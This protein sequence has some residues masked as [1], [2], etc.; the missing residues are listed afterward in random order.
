[1]RNGVL[2]VAHE[3][4]VADTATAN[5]SDGHEGTLT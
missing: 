2:V 3:T 4:T 1:V 5:T